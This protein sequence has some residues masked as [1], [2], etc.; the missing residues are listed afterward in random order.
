VH[1]LSVALSI[2]ESAEEEVSRQ[3][4]GRVHCVHLRLGPLS[5]VV[6][7]ALLFSYWLACEGTPLEGSALLIQDVPLRIYCPGCRAETP[8]VSLQKLECAQCGSPADRITQ[9]DE[10]EVAALE[11]ET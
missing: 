6:K 1:E 10:L 11:L 7:D 2:I 8:P 3:G 4:G 5:G 9:G